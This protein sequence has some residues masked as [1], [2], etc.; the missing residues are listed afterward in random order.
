MAR[1]RKA[2]IMV[3][4]IWLGEAVLAVVVALVVGI[5][6][7]SFGGGLFGAMCALAF[8]MF[9]AGMLGF[10]FGGRQSPSGPSSD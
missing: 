1:R 9:L 4:S 5:A 8:L 2:W 6:F 7:H 10:A 3:W